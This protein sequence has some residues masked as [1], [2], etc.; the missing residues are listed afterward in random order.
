[1]DSTLDQ[2]NSTVAPPP[3]APAAKVPAKTA[4]KPAA[5]VVESHPDP[6]VNKVRRRIV[7]ASV[8][9]FLTT[10]FLMFVRFFSAA[11]DLRAFEY[12]QNWIFGRLRARR[13]HEISAA[14]SHLG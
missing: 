10:C 8:A 11:R 2:Q 3:A 13:R 14:V 4:A 1:V 12:F 5:V 9:G 7:W 6:P